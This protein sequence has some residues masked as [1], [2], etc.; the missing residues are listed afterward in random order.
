MFETLNRVTIIALL[1]RR[2]RAHF[3][4][5]SVS[6]CNGRV[7]F[8]NLFWVW[9]HT[10]HSVVNIQPVSV[11]YII[12]VWCFIICLY[13]YYYGYY[14]HVSLLTTLCYWLWA[15]SRHPWLSSVGWVGGE[16]RVADPKSRWLLLGLRAWCMT[17]KKKRKRENWFQKCCYFILY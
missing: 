9:K 4:I 2:F 11:F 14:I 6:R 10:V 3:A 8:D 12:K 7:K 13:S 5:T 1:Y 16:A 15:H 17:K